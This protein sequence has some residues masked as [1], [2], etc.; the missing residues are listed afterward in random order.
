M[1]FIFKI[2]KKNVCSYRLMNNNNL[3]QFLAE[4][5]YGQTY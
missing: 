2:A 3:K 5:L 1:Y 4:Q